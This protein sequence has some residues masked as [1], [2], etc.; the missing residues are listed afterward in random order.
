[1]NFD[2]YHSSRSDLIVAMVNGSESLNV[3]KVEEG[4]LRRKERA[5][6]RKMRSSELWS[7]R[8]KH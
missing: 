8:K 2:G 4:I 6:L 5:L 1:M 7:D 3:Q